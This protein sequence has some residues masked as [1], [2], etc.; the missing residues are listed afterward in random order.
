MANTDL[1]NAGADVV[2]AVVV[3]DGT[4][5]TSRSPEDL[6]ALC[7]RILREFAGGPGRD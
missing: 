3:T 5:T 6:P 4:L 7:Q 2:D 1:R